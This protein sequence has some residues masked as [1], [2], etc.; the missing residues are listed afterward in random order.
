MV[1]A[2]P[3]RRA[4]GLRRDLAPRRDEV[5]RGAVAIETQR[6]EST[7]GG[8]ERAFEFVPSRLP[9]H[10]SLRLRDDGDGVFRSL[11]AR[12]ANVPR[13]CGTA[14]GVARVLL[15]LRVRLLLLLRGRPVR[16][17]EI[18]GEIGGDIGGGIGA[19]SL[20]LAAASFAAFAAAFAAFASA[21]ASSALSSAS[22]RAAAAMA[23]R[24]AAGMPCFR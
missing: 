24:S 15:L 23:S 22:A 5:I 21:S 4:G 18:G 14:L 1:R 12:H 9:P 6:L 8:A 7:F 2:D 17:G 20:R 13:F 10:A 16:R 3:R 19:D 11:D